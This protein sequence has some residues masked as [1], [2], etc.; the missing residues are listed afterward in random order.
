M[1]I[2]SSSSS[3]KKKVCGAITRQPLFY[4]ASKRKVVQSEGAASTAPALEH[5]DSATIAEEAAENL[6]R[7][8]EASDDECDSD[9]EGCDTHGGAWRSLQYASYMA[10]MHHFVKE[11]HRAQGY[12][13]AELAKAD[14]EMGEGQQDPTKRPTLEV[15]IATSAFNSRTTR[16]V[17]HCAWSFEAADIYML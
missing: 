7:R 17:R 11:K 13:A 15:Q 8:L 12:L 14:H 3:P 10:G 5:S 16:A 1:K 4:I 6:V 2:I 9:E